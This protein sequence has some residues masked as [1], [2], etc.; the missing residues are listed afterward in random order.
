MHSTIM[1]TINEFYG[2][3]LKAGLNEREKALKQHGFI[4]KKKDDFGSKFGWIHTSFIQKEQFIGLT[5]RL[6]E[7]ESIVRRSKILHPR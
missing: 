1:D 6:T 2:G 3:Q 7:R 5:R 4:I